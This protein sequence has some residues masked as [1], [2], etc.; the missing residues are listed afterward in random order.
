MNAVAK[1][2]GLEKIIGLLYT[3]VWTS[4]HELETENIK[5]QT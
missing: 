2:N 3:K 1:I 5:I 4:L